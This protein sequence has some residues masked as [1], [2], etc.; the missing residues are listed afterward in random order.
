MRT[1]K[2]ITEAPL[3]VVPM[4]RRVEWANNYNSSLFM[5]IQ[6]MFLL[7]CGVYENT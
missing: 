5:S 6:V 1:E 7:Q 3:I 2:Q 4:E